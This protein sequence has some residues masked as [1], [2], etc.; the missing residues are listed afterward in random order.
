MNYRKLGENEPKVSTLGLGCM[1]MSEFYG[2]PDEEESITAIHRALDLGITF[3][4]SADIY[5]PYTNEKLVGKAISDRREEVVLATK[6]VSFVKM[7]AWPST[8]D[9]N[10]CSRHVK[11]A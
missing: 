9:Q 3:L 4:D 10:T 5:G 6:F 2:T 8:G 1:G 7:V 11:I